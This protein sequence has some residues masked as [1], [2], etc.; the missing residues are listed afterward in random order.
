MTEPITLKDIRKAISLI[1]EGKEEIIWE[2]EDVIVTGRYGIPETIKLK[3]RA[4]KEVRMHMKKD[5][6]IIEKNQKIGKVTTFCG[7]PIFITDEKNESEHN[8]MPPMRED[9]H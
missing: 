9:Y 8:N 7:V 3:K 1:E 6:E 5:T 4:A 2:T